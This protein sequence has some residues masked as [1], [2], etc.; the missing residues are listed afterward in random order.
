MQRAALARREAER[1]EAARRSAE[2]SAA[3]LASAERTK[4][5]QG[6][7][8]AFDLELVADW[9]KGAAA[10]VAVKA[11]QERSARDAQATQQ[12]AE[13][14]ARQ[15]LAAVSNE[16]KMIDTHRDKFRHMLVAE[17]ESSEEE[18]ATEQWTASH[19]PS[20]RL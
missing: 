7:L 14:A 13:V 8:R 10:E 9:Q 4:L 16:A 1:A 5:E 17:Q 2:R 11:D 20:R 18:A 12:A 3:L 6:L 19:F 15:T